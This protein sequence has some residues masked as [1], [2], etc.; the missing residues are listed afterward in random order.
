M[1]SYSQDRF[2]VFK[3]ELRNTE[4]RLRDIEYLEK[5]GSHEMLSIQT[6]QAHAPMFT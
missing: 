4:N 1:K 5:N 6:K 2:H 3:K